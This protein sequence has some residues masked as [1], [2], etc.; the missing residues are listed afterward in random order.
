MMPDL[1]QRLAVLNPHLPDGV[2]LAGAA[3]RAGRSA[4]DHHL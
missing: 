2:P 4:A 1:E 3:R